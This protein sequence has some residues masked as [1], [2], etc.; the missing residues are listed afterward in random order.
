MNRSSLLSEEL[1]KALDGGALSMV[2]CSALHYD[3]KPFACWSDIGHV[4]RWRRRFSP[5]AHLDAPAHFWL[6]HLPLHQAGLDMCPNVSGDT[7]RNGA[8]HAAHTTHWK[9]VQEFRTSHA[10]HAGHLQPHAPYS[11]PLTG[12]CHRDHS[13]ASVCCRV[14]TGSSRL[15][16]SCREHEMALPARSPGCFNRHNSV[17]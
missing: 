15:H 10:W 8:A 9:R 11:H 7:G 14:R 4:S 12:G 13:E 17:Q 16:G 3:R 6:P 1:T 2:C 5:F